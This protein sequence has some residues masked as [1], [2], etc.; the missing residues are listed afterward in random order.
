MPPTVFQGNSRGCWKTSPRRRPAAGPAARRVTVPAVGRSK[1]AISR[2]RVLLPQPDAPD[3][4]QELPGGH[5]ER[6]RPE[7][8]DGAGAVAVHLVA[9]TSHRRLRPWRSGAGHGPPRPW[10]SLT[11]EDIRQPLRRRWPSQTVRGPAPRRSSSVGLRNCGGAE[12]VLR[13][14]AERALGGP[15][16]RRAARSAGLRNTPCSAGA[17]RPRA[18]VELRCRR[19]SAAAAGSSGIGRGP[20]PPPCARRRRPR[21]A[22][23]RTRRTPTPRSSVGLPAVASSRLVIE[24]LAGLLQLVQRRQPDVGGVDVAAGPGGEDVLR[25]RST[26]SPRTP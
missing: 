7:R 22:R 25:L 10:R 24:D 13:Q 2:S 1:P 20:A 12:Q 21:G 5:V 4:H 3:Q 9:S 16:H 19:P 11:G 26:R 18:D 15:S 14:V 17:R 6:E 8:G 23:A